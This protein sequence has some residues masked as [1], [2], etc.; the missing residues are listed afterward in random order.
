M[1]LQ[2][3]PNEAEVRLEPA[4]GQERCYEQFDIVSKWELRRPE[5]Y[6]L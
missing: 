5:R 2:R 4:H 1:S 6:N 3:T